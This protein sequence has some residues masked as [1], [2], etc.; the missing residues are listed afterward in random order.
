METHKTKTPI[1]FW[2]ISVPLLILGIMGILQINSVWGPEMTE[3]LWAKL[4]YSGGIIGILIGSLLLVFRKIS[5]LYFFIFSLAG[6]L[7]HRAWIFGFSERAEEAP[8][9]LFL[10]ILII[11]ISILLVRLGTK[12]GWI[13]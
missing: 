3:P 4:C 7:I 5:A 1:W 12:K 6:F 10:P 9:T 13:T 8:W 2:F 11:I